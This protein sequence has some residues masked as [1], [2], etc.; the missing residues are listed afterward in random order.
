MKFRNKVRDMSKMFLFY[1]FYNCKSEINFLKQLAKHIFCS[2][3]CFPYNMYLFILHYLFQLLMVSSASQYE[4]FFCNC[5]LPPSLN[6]S[7]VGQVTLDKVQQGDKKKM[8][9]QSRKLDDSS[10]PPLS[11]S[12]RHCLP[13]SSTVINA[14][15]SSTLTVK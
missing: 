12:Q 1:C 6:E 11:V 10:N 4:G 2:L 7:K 15:S 14:S 9:S 5:V 8:R 3:R 13:P